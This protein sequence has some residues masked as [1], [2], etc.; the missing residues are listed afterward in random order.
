MNLSDEE[1]I[2]NMIKKHEDEYHPEQSCFK[3]LWDIFVTPIWFA[4]FFVFLIPLFYKLF[5]FWVNVL[6]INPPSGLLGF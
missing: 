5:L 4:L 6:T 2:E 1:L 3:I